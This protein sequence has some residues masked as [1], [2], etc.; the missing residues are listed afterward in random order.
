MFS[1]DGANSNTTGYEREP[2][3]SLS[4]FLRSKQSQNDLNSYRSPRSPGGAD[5]SMNSD[6]APGSSRVDARQRSVSATVDD[7]WNALP[8]RSQSAL[9]IMSRDSFGPTTRVSLNP[10]LAR[11]ES[12]IEED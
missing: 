6:F 2:R 9:G 1:N 3:K 12:G 11:L 4:T 8:P 5:A 10:R 7:R